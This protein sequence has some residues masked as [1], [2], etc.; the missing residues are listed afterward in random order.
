MNLVLDASATLA[1][2]YLEKITDA[3]RRLLRSASVVTN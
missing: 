2:L 3:I 1:W